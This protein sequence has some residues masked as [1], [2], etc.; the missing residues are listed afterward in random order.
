MDEK[1]IKV[2]RY[3]TGE[4]IINYD[5]NGRIMPYRWAGCRG[6]KIDTKSIPQHVVDW[7]MMNTTVFPDGDLVIQKNEETTELIK[8][9]DDVRSY[10]ANTHTR[11]EII[12]I[13][14]SNANSMK[15]KLNKVTKK[16]EKD[17]VIDIAKEIKLDSNVKR[18]FLAE[19]IGIDPELLFED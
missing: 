16:E 6:K 17:F 19:W 8:N 14:N 10:N 4:Y 12:E 13:L 2:S 11:D 1:M 3:R 15:S 18:K 7:L 5:T 9:I